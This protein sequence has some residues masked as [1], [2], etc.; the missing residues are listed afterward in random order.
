[1]KKILLFFLILFPAILSAQEY[2]TSYEY[3]YTVEN[4][5]RSEIIE[6]KSYVT[7]GYQGENEI[8][9]TF[10]DG[11][12]IVMRQVTPARQKEET[13]EKTAYFEAIIDDEPVILLIELN[14][15]HI[16]FVFTESDYIELFNF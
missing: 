3:V 12:T 11:S 2:T 5:V 8:Q 14:S 7:F 4:G 10:S 13:G 1:M 15:A 6:E 16:R 9:V